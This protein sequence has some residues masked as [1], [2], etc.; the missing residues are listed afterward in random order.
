MKGGKMSFE[1]PK[2]SLKGTTYPNPKK[3]SK[4]VQFKNG[5]YFLI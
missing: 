5:K 1:Y 2:I 3:V 4:G